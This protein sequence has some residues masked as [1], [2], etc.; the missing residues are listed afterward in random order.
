MNDNMTLQEALIEVLKGSKVTND[1]WSP[2]EYITHE[3]YMFV[4][5][6]G[7]ELTMGGLPGNGYMIWSYPKKT[8]VLEQ[9]L[10]TL[11]SDEDVSFVENGT[12]EFFNKFYPET[13]YSYILL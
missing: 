11:L 9:R 7:E 8:K 13:E 12:E 5:E 2:T 4:D 3:Y 6:D 1:G 10:V